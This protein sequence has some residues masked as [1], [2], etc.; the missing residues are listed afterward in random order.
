MLVKTDNKR[1][2]ARTSA[3]SL[4]ELMTQSCMVEEDMD[5]TSSEEHFVISDSTPAL[6][7]G[8]ALSVRNILVFQI[9]R[10][11]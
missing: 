5:M 7:G 10:S 6:I 9:V 11:L 3:M 2:Q 4:S 8:T 1:D